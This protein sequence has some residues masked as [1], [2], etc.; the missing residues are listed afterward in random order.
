LVCYFRFLALGAL[1]A[2]H[3]RFGYKVLPCVLVGL[4]ALSFA[5]ATGQRAPR[6]ML[7]EAAKYLDAHASPG[8]HVVVVPSGPTLV[9]LALYLRSDV[10]L[11]A[12]PPADLPY[13]VSASAD[14]DHASWFAIQHL[15]VPTQEAT[16]S[17]VGDGAAR[18]ETIRFPALDLFRVAGRE[19]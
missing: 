4:M 16:I 5:T 3:T 15:G 17:A 8:D 2:V 11:G 6:Q 18:G 1:A 13:A 19:L 14:R 9:G 7:R 10:D 12:V